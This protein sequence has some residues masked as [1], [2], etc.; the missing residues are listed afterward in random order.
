M[1][2]TGFTPTSAELERERATRQRYEAVL[3]RI[4]QQRGS[5]A[6]DV[7]REALAAPIC[8]QCG[9]PFSEP[10]CGPTHA[11][12]AAAQEGTKA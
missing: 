7:A 12:L 11:A 2:L 6:S 1:S 5:W 9:Q 4:A 10:A 8:G 3:R